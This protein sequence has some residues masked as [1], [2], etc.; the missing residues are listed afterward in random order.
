MI[1]WLTLRHPLTP[2]LGPV[3]HGRIMEALGRIVCVNAAGE[4]LWEKASPDWDAIR[5]DTPGLMWSVTGNAEGQH[6]LTIGAS[7]AALQYGHNVFGSDDVRFCAQVLIRFAASCLS[8][9]LPPVERWECR[10]I[11]VTHNYDLGGQDEVKSALRIL[12]GSDSARRRATTKAK[13]GDSI[14]WSPT[15]DLRS[16]KAYHKGPH[17]RHLK[18]IGRYLNLSDS[19]IDLADRLIRFELK[20]GSR[21]FRRLEEGRL[22]D[23]PR[24]WLQLTP[25]HLNSQHSEFFYS[26]IGQVEVTDMTNLLQ[27]L[28]Q[29]APTMGQAKSAHTLWLNIRQY[30]YEHMKSKTPVSTWTRNKKLL[31]LAGLSDSD[32]CASN[33]LPFRRRQIVLSQP[34]TSWDDLRMAA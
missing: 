28:E 21:W 22:K 7:P 5:S 3:V 25:D 19:L 9:L 16:G 23:L 4:K 11:D 6:M 34:I 8:A 33:I 30:G 13:G 10:R 26:F 24:N 15:S 27:L 14:Y 29:V 20:L 12:M 17:L 32:L 1:D 2:A 18:K 31:K